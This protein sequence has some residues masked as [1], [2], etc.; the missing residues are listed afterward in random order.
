MI[1]LRPLTKIKF[2]Y[3]FLSKLNYLRK[4][5]KLGVLFYN[6]EKDINNNKKIY[7]KFN[8][9]FDPKYKGSYREKSVIKY[10]LFTALSK[11]K[12]KIQKILEIGTWDGEFTNLL[13][14]LFS[15]SKIFT[16]DLP[17]TDERFVNSYNRRDQL[18]NF[19]NKRNN[20][21]SKK[22]IKF[23][24]M[25]SKNL[26]EKFEKN[27]FDIIWVDGDHHDPTVT[28]DIF[29]SYEILKKG[30]IMIV[31]DLLLAGKSENS[32]KH[33][34]EGSSTDGMVALKKLSKEKKCDFSLLTKFYGPR[35]YFRTS[36]NAIL[37]K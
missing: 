31:D 33:P 20:N 25:D 35:N 17:H 27:S 23:I 16:I 8:L 26:L 9:D 36:Y 30:G 11:K 15:E 4:K 32:K 28:R 37:K 2:L 14:N 29:N 34:S 3:Y 5:K 18:N 1:F 21:L 24:E 13:S 6:I 22:N 10:K 19:I 12:L 7:E